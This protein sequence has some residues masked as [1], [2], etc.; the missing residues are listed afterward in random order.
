MREGRV[1]VEPGYD[2]EYGTIH[3]FGE[4]EDAPVAAGEQQMTL[5]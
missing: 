4:A 1:T 2:G 3:L 5:F